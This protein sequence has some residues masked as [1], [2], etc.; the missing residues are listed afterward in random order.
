MRTAPAPP[1]TLS[2]KAI[3]VQGATI[4]LPPPI[5]APCSTLLI[6]CVRVARGLEV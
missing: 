2:I 6:G 5:V 3:I 1:T 4:E